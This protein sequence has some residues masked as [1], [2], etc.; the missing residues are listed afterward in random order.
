M[1]LAVRRLGLALLLCGCNSACAGHFF[2]P[3]AK[4]FLKSGHW[5]YSLD[6]NNDAVVRRYSGTGG[7]IQ[8]PSTIDGH[9]VRGIGT[10]AYFGSPFSQLHE[11]AM[12]LVPDTVNAVY[13]GAFA[14]SERLTNV[15]LPPSVT[16]FGESV[17]SGSKN[18]VAASLPAGLCNVPS[19]TFEGCVAL[20]NV[21]LSINAVRIESGAFAG[22]ARLDRLVIPESVTYIGAHAFQDCSRL[23]GIVIPKGVTNI[24]GSAFEGCNSLGSIAI[25]DSVKTIGHGAFRGCARLTNVAIGNGFTNDGGSLFVGAP[26]RSA[27]IDT[28]VASWRPGWGPAEAFE[29]F[30]GTNVR[31]VGSFS[32]TGLAEIAIP[33]GVVSIADGAFQGC[34]N[35]TTVAIPDSVTSIGRSAFSDCTSLTNVTIGRGVTNIGDYAFSGSTDLKAVRLPDGIRVIGDYAFAGCTKLRKVTIAIGPTKIGERAFSGCESLG[36][37][38]IPDSVTQIGYGAFHG[39]KALLQVRLPTNWLESGDP[40]NIFDK[41]PAPL[42]ALEVAAGK[43]RQ[44]FAESIMV[45]V[46]RGGSVEIPLRGM[47]QSLNRLEYRI[48]GKPQ[49]GSL[50]AVMQYAESERQDPGFVTYTHGGDKVST[51]DAFDF[52]AKDPATGRAGRGRVTV[53]MDDAVIISPPTMLDFGTVAVGDPPVRRNFEFCNAG[54]GIIKWIA[55][56]P[57]PF[58]LLGE[59]V[60]VLHPGEKVTIPVLFAPRNVG[61]YLFPIQLAPGNPAVLTL[62]GEAMHPF[63]VEASSC[64]FEEQPDGSRTARATIKNQSQNPQQIFVTFPSETPVKPVPTVELAP[65]E[66]TEVT[67]RIPSGQKT[68]A[69]P[70][71]VCFKNPA[72][73]VALDFQ[74]RDIP[75]PRW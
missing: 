74:A 10:S 33:D 46:R 66:V 54:V 45:K 8:V 48:I 67:L 68:K 12:V 55:A 38:A 29:V 26:L 53:M 1:F 35:L 39:C 20:T 15:I 64:I 13:Q 3:S 6:E 19:G 73:T 34:T 69:A 62:K 36:K 37:I 47:H 49:H 70:F 14:D 43:R 21:S 71:T 60:Y 11:D 5:E 4:Q 50:S 42:P 9:M 52:D 22:C 59:S 44:P 72:H 63:A 41:Q 40:F 17:F 61:P 51:R 31:V 58:T 28:K 65:G 75:A 30:L 18:L 16:N 57:E 23:K 7:L 27:S 2:G 24:M 32:H 56:V 25:P